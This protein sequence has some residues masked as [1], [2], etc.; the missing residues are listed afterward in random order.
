MPIYKQSYSSGKVQVFICVATL[1]DGEL[2]H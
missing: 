2:N 1:G